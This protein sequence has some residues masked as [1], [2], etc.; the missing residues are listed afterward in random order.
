VKCSEYL[1]RCL[2]RRTA[3]T[4]RPL[5][6]RRC[7]VALADTTCPRELLGLTAARLRLACEDLAREALVEV[8]VVPA[9]CRFA[10]L[11]VG[12]AY[13][14]AQR[15]RHKRM[16]QTDFKYLDIK[17]PASSTAINLPF[18]LHTA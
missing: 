13:A 3:S 16:A 15:P 7:V 9:L 2:V 12:S 5:R 8:W 18:P 14:P 4:A 11:V 6:R 17:D 1:D 10:S